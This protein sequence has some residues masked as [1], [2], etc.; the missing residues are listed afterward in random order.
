VANEC[1]KCNTENS[2][3]IKFCG[4]CGT[5]L[6]EKTFYITMEYVPAIDSRNICLSRKVRQGR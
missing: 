3:T 5:P 1:P 4:E 6:E 2:D